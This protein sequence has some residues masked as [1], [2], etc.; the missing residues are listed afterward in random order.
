MRGQPW[1]EATAGE[2]RVVRVGVPE[3]RSR[4]DGPPRSWR[5]P[6]MRQT[7]CGGEDGSLNGTK[8]RLRCVHLLPQVP[9]V[10]G[11]GSCVDHPSCS[12][13]SSPVGIRVRTLLGDACAGKCQALSNAQH[14]PPPAGHQCLYFPGDRLVHHK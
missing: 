3:H 2:P 1:R 12:T 10:T 13:L 4:K 9:A 6:R 14:T 11:A 5:G 7:G 8:V